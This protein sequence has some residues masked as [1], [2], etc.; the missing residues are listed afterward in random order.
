LIRDTQLDELAHFYQC[1]DAGVMATQRTAALNLLR[2]DGFRSIGAGLQ[3]V[4]QDITVLLVM[5]RR[6][7]QP[8][9]C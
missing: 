1:N 8:N 3:A 9:D 7:P 2:Q 4:V 6:Q 5:V